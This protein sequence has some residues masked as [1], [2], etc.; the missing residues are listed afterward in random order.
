MCV[1]EFCWYWYD[2][3]YCLG[4]ASETV[5]YRQ[6]RLREELDVSTIRPGGVGYVVAPPRQRSPPAPPRRNLPAVRSHGMFIDM[7]YLGN[8]VA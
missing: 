6:R 1:N 5:L 4:C 3:F 2:I 8:S 7:N